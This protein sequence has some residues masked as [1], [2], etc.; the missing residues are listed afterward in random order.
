M[1]HRLTARFA[2]ALVV[3]AVIGAIVLFVVFGY[4]ANYV[5]PQG[6]YMPPL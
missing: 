4:H 6:H 5:T 1:T 2:A 3:A